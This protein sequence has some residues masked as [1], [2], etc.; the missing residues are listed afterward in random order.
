MICFTHRSRDCAC[1]TVK[2]D[3]SVEYKYAPKL[4]PRRNAM[5]IYYSVQAFAENIAY[6]PAAM[7]NV[8]H[9]YLTVADVLSD[10]LLGP[11]PTPEE[12]VKSLV[13]IKALL[14]DAG[15]DYVG[16]AEEKT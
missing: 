3:D 7:K 14:K 6:S 5:E 1:V 15:F 4:V 10:F 2:K 12:T 11:S 16:E 13:K 9:S 8:V